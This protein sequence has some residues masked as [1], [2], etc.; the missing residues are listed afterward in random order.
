MRA[1][2]GAG[3]GGG[4]DYILS[5]KGNQKEISE[6]V[7]HLFSSSHPITSE[8]TTSAEKDHGRI[9][10]RICRVISVSSLS[11][12][13]YLTDAWSGLCSFVEMT[14]ICQKGDEITRQTRYFLSSLDASASDFSD[15]VRWHWGIEN[16]LHW[17]LDVG[18]REDWCRVR[19]GNAGTNL[20]ILRHFSLN[21]LRQDKS[22]KV[23]IKNRR[24]RAGWDESYLEKVI[25]N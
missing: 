9:E 4:A 10:K 22:S 20:S 24:L 21:L 7:T 14:R 19:S 18:F 25:T 11:G 3:V 12:W 6:A 8:Y 1:I 13:E 5:L 15:W 23:G 2:A 17:V 16:S